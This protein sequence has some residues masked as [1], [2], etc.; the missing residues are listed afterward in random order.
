VAYNTGTDPTLTELISRYFVPKI[1]SQAAIMH[2]KSNLVAQQ[3]CNT[4]YKSDLRKG[5]TVYIPVYTEGSATEVTPGTTATAGDHTTTGKS[6]TVDQWYY[7]A[8][9]ISHLGKVEDHVGYLKGATE[10]CAYTVA[11]KIDTDVG[12]LYSTTGGSTQANS[13]G[14]NFT[15][16]TFRSLVQTLDENDV[17]DE[18]RSLVGD[19]SMKSD[20]LNIDKFVRVDY[21]NNPAVPKGLI[22]QL[23]GAKVY[24]TNNLTAATHG[25][26]G[27]YMHRD[28]IGLA[29]QMNPN[30]H[31]HELGWEFR[32]LLIVDAAWGKAEIRDTFGKSFYTKSS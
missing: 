6:L 21:V 1:Y 11:K 31:I 32:F 4:T 20:I 29:V 2:T 27:I 13:D 8:A 17:P 18:S 30:V 22:G 28:C 19:P 25:N 7:D 9:D 10:S 15:D 23:Y 24:I 12:S 5:D 16:A 3:V 26:Y 14:D